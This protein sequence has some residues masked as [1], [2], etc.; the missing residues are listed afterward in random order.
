MALMANMC[1]LESKIRRELADEANQMTWSEDVLFDKILAG[2]AGAKTRNR[3][4]IIKWVL[5]AAAVVIAGAILVVFLTNG[6][7]LGRHDVAYA[8]EQAVSQLSSYHGVLETRTV[9]AA[10]KEVE[11]SQ[12]EIWWQEGKCAERQIEATNE[13]Q[14]DGTL[15]VN[16]GVQ[17]WQVQPQDKEVEMIP[18]Y[19]PPEAMLTSLDSLLAGLEFDLHYPH[20]VVGSEMVAGRQTEKL[21]ISPP[22]GSPYFLWVDTETN[23]PMQV[24][25]TQGGFQTTF[26]FI[27]FEPNARIDP[28][29][30]T[31]N[32]PAGY[33][34]IDPNPM[35]LVASAQ[36]AAA[37]SGLKP[38]LPPQAPK[39][40]YAHQG[41]IVLDYG[42]NIV[43]ET[44]AAGSF[45]DKVLGGP[46]GHY[47]V[48]AAAGGPLEVVPDM[49]LRWR[50]QGIEIEVEGL[51]TSS[52]VDLA[53]QIA[54][55]L[56]MP[57]PGTDLVGQAKVKL[58]ED[59]ADAR[60]DQSL[61][62]QNNFIANAETDPYY[63][64]FVF[65]NSKLSPPGTFSALKPSDYHWNGA[66]VPPK[67]WSGTP[68]IPDASFNLVANSG[69][70]AVVAVADG[71]ISKVFLK[72]LVRQDETGVWSVVGYD[73]R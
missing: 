4:G 61:T 3:A 68:K 63:V 5:P 24:Q 71:Q 28:A 47:L 58:P 40:I 19:P 67:G 34:V 35:Q 31:F 13:Q 7:G 64:A 65:V 41:R 62:G 8:M 6:A 45:E 16:N 32:P 44:P 49:S 48:G 14:F 9:N 55:D 72:R 23:L 46:Y 11:V 56:T 51:R 25:K 70:E 73:P 57:D 66:G 69:V 12:E 42:E 18:P 10:G 37:V 59:L 53:R 50:E 1:E 43:M 20:A 33:K 60:T 30:F 26:T 29:I 36:E 2:I 21:K 38:L 27:S 15:T 54:P 22:G 17:R 39:H 52:M